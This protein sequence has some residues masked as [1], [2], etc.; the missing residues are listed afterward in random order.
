MSALLY[1]LGR[2]CASHAKRVV[3]AWLAI[4]ALFAAVVVLHG[5]DMNGP[6]TLSGTESM[7]G[8]TVLQNRLPQIAGTS[9]E[10]LFTSE[11]GDI[12]SHKAEIEDFVDEVKEIDGVA[13]VSAPFGAKQDQATST[14]AQESTV[15]KD[16]RSVIVQVIA[17]ADYGS[18]NTGQ[19]DKAKDL[20][21]EL[22]TLVSSTEKSTGLTIHQSEAIGKEVQMGASAAEVIGVVVAGIVLLITFGSFL[23]AG[24]PLVSSLIGVASGMLG[25]LAVS[26][27]SPVVPL[28]PTL[29]MMLGLAVGIDYALFIISRAREYLT[30]DPAHPDRE[31]AT[32]AEA[33]G[34]AVATAGSAVVFAG[35]TV[36][37]ALLGL[38]VCGI[39]FLTLM[40]VAAAF[41]VAMAVLVALTFTPA[42]IGMIGVRM[43]PN[44]LR[45][46]REA[47]KAAAGTKSF[48]QRWVAFVTAKPWITVVA[49]IAILGTLTLPA[50]ALHLALT[51][52]GYEAKGTVARETYDAIS[53]AYGPGYNS[54]IIV[55]A[56]ITNTR[57]PIDTVN[58]LADEI[59]KIPGV[60]DVAMATPNSDGTLGVIEIRPA[61]GQADTRTENVVKT[62]R[63]NASHYKSEYGITDVMV[64][65]QTAVAIDI[66]QSLS[67]A[68]LP[69]GIVVVGL[70]LVLL[71]IV[72]RSVAVP[73]TATL[74]Y[75]LSLGAGMGV[76]G[77]IFGWGWLADFFD[78]PKVGAVICFLPVI[79][80]GILFGLAMD[81]EVFLVSRM[82]EE[83]THHHDARQAVLSGY[84][85]SARVVSAAAVIMTAVFAGF[86]PAE[87]VIIKPIAVSLA[88]GIFFDAFLV[89]QTFIPAIMMALGEKAWWMP[90]WLDRNLP[91]IDVEGEGLQRTLEHNDWTAEHGEVAV[92]ADDVR[93]SDADGAAL[94]HLDLTVAAGEVALVRTAEPIAR[95]ALQALIG[96]RLQPTSGILV[97]GGHVLPDGTA[98]IQ[99]MTTAVHAYD[100]EID[101]RV[102]VVVVDDPGERRWRRAAE[103]ARQGVAVIVT[104][105]AE[106]PSMA[107]PS[108]DVAITTLID[109][110]ADGT[111]HVRRAPERRAA[112]PERDDAGTPDAGSPDAAPGRPGRHSILHATPTSGTE[113]HA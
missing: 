83:W 82:R 7:E 93:V 72:F 13:S 80:M 95:R 43:R 76:T 59:G 30:E 64:T 2:W 34:R 105:D 81:Y 18:V 14:P 108:A 97:I 53:D 60:D 31:L 4:I 66:G 37:V 6:Y 70:S 67:D 71:L 109:V 33:A 8:L 63:N 86:I 92:R 89:R 54:P 45:A 52:D 69:F 20:A 1:R 62:I 11:D 41:V 9:D 112:A 87:L 88:F 25:V 65:G 104:T 99:A 107:P 44:P 23:A 32:P 103:L 84:T 73:V 90:A 16:G 94:A 27:W 19:T 49:V 38:A 51:D 74:G 42:L 111:A 78:V 17:D 102:R 113:A 50:K 85:G 101:E 96:G 56:D 24:A 57:I 48:P 5:F 110:A 47:A 39:P 26:K 58:D 91:I 75:I 29:A 98:A 28:A 100:D 3:A 22:S 61:Y 12:E 55:I 77:A 15:S 21:K 36:V 46:R 35:T 68:M 106:K 10:V 40:G 79:T